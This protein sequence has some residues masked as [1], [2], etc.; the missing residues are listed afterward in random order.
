MA[1]Y[2]FTPS[3]AYALNTHE[4]TFTKDRLRIKLTSTGLFVYDEDYSNGIAFRCDGNNFEVGTLNATQVFVKQV[5]F[6]SRKAKL[7]IVEQ[8]NANEFIG[9][10]DMGDTSIYNI[11]NINE[12]PVL[13]A[14]NGTNITEIKCPC[15]GTPCTNGCYQYG[16]S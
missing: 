8:N 9:T 16:Q 7:W 5:S 10:N 6:S 3:S 12:C 15:D 11:Y 4:V 2:T 14:K 13:I 1:S